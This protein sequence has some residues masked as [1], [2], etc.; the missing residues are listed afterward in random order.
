MNLT[1]N[2]NYRYRF[3]FWKSMAGNNKDDTPHIIHIRMYTKIANI[4]TKYTIHVLFFV[5][6]AINHSENTLKHNTDST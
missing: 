4:N 5:T 2:R 6:S 3:E 1:W